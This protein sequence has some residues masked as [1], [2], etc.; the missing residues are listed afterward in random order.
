MGGGPMGVCELCYQGA[1]DEEIAACC[2]TIDAADLNEETTVA[3]A[4]R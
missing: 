3:T 2:V 4:L 1:S